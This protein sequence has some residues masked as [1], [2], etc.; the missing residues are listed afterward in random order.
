MVAP[1]FDVSGIQPDIGPL[2]LDWAAQEGLHPLV[3]LAAQSRDLAFGDAVHPHGPYQI[4]D[5]AGRDALDISFLDHGGQRLLGQPARFEKGREIAAAPQLGDA[6][7]D[8]TRTGLPVTVP[9]AIALVA[10]LRTAFAVPGA[11]QRFTL[12]LHHALGGKAD[13]L[14]QECGIGALLQKR[15]KGDLLVGHRG[16]PRVRVACRNPTL[17]RIATM[18]ANQP[19]CASLLAVAP[20]GRPAASYTITRDTTGSLSSRCFNHSLRHAN[21]DSTH[22][23]KTAA[24]AH[25]Q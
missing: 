4:V 7:F 9:A 19:A 18:A 16:D 10:P 3:D 5:R 20:A 11:A 12:Q 17:L 8:V 6:Q 25:C 15:T 22:D 13:H 1:C 2:A 14:A 23:L 21:A 24:D